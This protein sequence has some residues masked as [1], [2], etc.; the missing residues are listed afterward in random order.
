MLWVQKFNIYQEKMVLQYTWWSSKQFCWHKCSWKDTRRHMWHYHRHEWLCHDLTTM[1]S[2][3]HVST[4]CHLAINCIS[5]YRDS[6]EFRSCV[7]TMVRGRAPCNHY[8]FLNGHCD[9]ICTPNW[10]NIYKYTHAKC[11]TTLVLNSGWNQHTMK[12]GGKWIRS[13][14]REEWYML[15]FIMNLNSCGK[16]DC[17][18]MEARIGCRLHGYSSA[19]QNHL[20]PNILWTYNAYVEVIKGVVRIVCVFC[21]Y[22]HVECVVALVSDICTCQTPTATHFLWQQ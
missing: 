19:S 14:L 9:H 4:P 21:R 7:P 8:V 17:R 22:K 15:N 6:I 12:T 18:K 1:S 16:I 11:V 5:H 2:I 3:R 20:R 10:T 13:S